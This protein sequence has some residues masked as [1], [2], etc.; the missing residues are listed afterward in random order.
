MFSATAAFLAISSDG[1][2]PYR[3]NPGVWARK[4]RTPVITGNLPG[5]VM[6]IISGAPRVAYKTFDRLFFRLRLQSVQ[7]LLHQS[8]SQVFLFVDGQ[9]GV[10]GNMN[11]PVAKNYPV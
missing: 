8:A 11:N 7:R 1:L 2:F 4:C 9:I 5:D 10:S 6:P 3:T